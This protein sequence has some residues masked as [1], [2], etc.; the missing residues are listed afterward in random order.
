MVMDIFYYSVNTGDGSVVFTC[1]SEQ[2]CTIPGSWYGIQPSLIWLFILVPFLLWQVKMSSVKANYLLITAD[3]KENTNKADLTNV[4]KTVKLS[5]W[6]KRV[7][8]VWHHRAGV[9]P[10]NFLLW[11]IFSFLD[12]EVAQGCTRNKRRLNSSGC[13]LSLLWGSGFNW[14]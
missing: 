14:T 4:I 2:T 12:T 5:S 11:K 7:I 13:T 3:S 6:V 8:G 1:P 10:Y 9:I